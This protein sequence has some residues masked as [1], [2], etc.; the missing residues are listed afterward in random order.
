MSTRLVATAAL[1]LLAL[2]VA[3]KPPA[4]EPP[5]VT[6]A[7]RE[8]SNTEI[9][10]LGGTATAPHAEV[11]IYI[12]GEGGAV[13]S[14]TVA[15]DEDGAWFY[16]HAEFLPRGSY[17]VW[18]QLKVDDSLS[19]PSP[20]IGLT[21]IPTAFQFGE[22]RLSYEQVYLWI[23]L[24]LLGLIVALLIFT[25]YHARSLKVKRA[26]LA[27]EV[28]E[29]EEAVHKGFELLHADINAELDT[30]RKAKLS[31]ELS[32]EE[33]LREEKML[34]DLGLIESMIAREVSDIER[35]LAV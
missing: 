24:A 20:E 3:A 9:F 12:Q 18:T 13:V 14:A 29:A 27:K 21:V 32:A 34:K 8:I 26:R 25:A 7:A 33:K 2:P 11:L 23:A 16:T 17:K 19:P 28:R 30:V 15:T 4:I 35:E 1:L 31:R 22:R 5:F 6:V 10:Y